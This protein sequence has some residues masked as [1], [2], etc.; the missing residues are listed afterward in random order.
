M[1]AYRSHPVRVRGLKRSLTTAYLPHAM[2]HPVRVRGLKQISR[3]TEQS[4]EVAPRAGAWVETRKE[5]SQKQKAR[6]HPVR[7]RGLKHQPGWQS[8]SR[9]HVAPRAGAWVETKNHARPMYQYLRSHRA[10]AWVETEEISEERSRG[11]RR[12]PCGC[13]G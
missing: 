8:G 6:S 1:I 2:S 12:T 11:L 5:L 3:E 4:C 10:G 13:V 9:F 7:L